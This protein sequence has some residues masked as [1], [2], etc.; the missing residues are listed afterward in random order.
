MSRLLLAGIVALGVGPLHLVPWSGTSA[1]AISTLNSSASEIFNPNVPAIVGGIVW[2]LVVA[3]VLGSR[4][5]KRLG[6]VD[7]EYNH[8]NTLTEEQ[9]L[10]RRPK[11]IWANAAMTMAL[12]LILM[13]G[14]IPAPVLFVLASVLA[15]IINYPVLKDQ[16]KVLKSHGSNIFM[17]GCGYP[18][19]YPS[20]MMVVMTMYILNYCHD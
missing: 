11:L 5:R 12:I 7:F 17:V 6:V 4:E 3:F 8:G 15:L 13:K 16:A 14:W 2:V 10:L 9:I 1:R 19:H 18:A 20:G